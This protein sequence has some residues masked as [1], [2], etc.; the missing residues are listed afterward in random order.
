MKFTLL[1]CGLL[2]VAMPSAIFAEPA[3][4]GKSN[5]LTNAVILV[6]RHAEKPDAQPR[7]HAGALTHARE[8]ARMSGSEID[9]VRTLLQAK[10]RK[11]TEDWFRWF[12]AEWNVARTIKKGRQRVVREYLDRDFRKDLLDGGGAETVDAAAA[13]IQRKG[14]SS[15]KRKNGQGSLPISLVSKIGF[16]LCPT[17]LV[18]LDRYAV[19]GLNELRRITCAPRLKERSYRGYLEAFN[20]QMPG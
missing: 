11:L 13:H 18:P 3:Q 10:P 17:R 15:Q 14:W 6:I 20:E 9:A 7:R 19:R 4:D 1:F 16:F 5:A 12:V 8:L 2:A